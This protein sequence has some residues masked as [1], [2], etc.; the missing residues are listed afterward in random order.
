MCGVA[1]TELESDSTPLDHYHSYTDQWRNPVV[2][3][4]CPERFLVF[5]GGADIFAFF[6]RGAMDCE[7]CPG[8][9]LNNAPATACV[10]MLEFFLRWQDE[11][12]EIRRRLHRPTYWQS[13]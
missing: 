6:L 2:E 11:L 7:T 4:A 5:L 1:L 9:D 3:I 13:N 10:S 8:I 12:K